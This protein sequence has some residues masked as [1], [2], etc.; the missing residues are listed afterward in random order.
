MNKLSAFFI[1]FLVITK[2]CAQTSDDYPIFGYPTND[3][4]KK[5]KSEKVKEVI[6]ISCNKNDSLC[7][8]PTIDNKWFFNKKGNLKHEWVYIGEENGI[9]NADIYYKYRKGK[10]IRMKSNYKALVNNFYYYDKTGALIKEIGKETPDI[11]RTDFI[12]SH[13]LLIQKNCSYKDS[14]SSDNKDSTFEVFHTDYYYYNDEGFLIKHRAVGDSPDLYAYDSTG[15][16]IFE[17][18]VNYRDTNV[19]LQETDY[20][21]DTKYLT[22]S[23]EYLNSKFV[24]A[25]YYY[26]NNSGLLTSIRIEFYFQNQLSFRFEN[27]KYKYY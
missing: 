14:R 17:K 6:V 2:I 3:Y 13:C 11:I 12:Y 5:L 9:M 21:Y 7:T 19:V 22:S 10:L 25:K 20:F 26:Y 27:Y 4:E 15:R 24:G 23:I 16:V 18:K 8:S 1:L